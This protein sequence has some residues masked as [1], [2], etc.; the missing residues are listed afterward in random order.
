MT[1]DQRAAGVSSDMVTRFQTAGPNI[2]DLVDTA[3]LSDSSLATLMPA[4]LTELKASGRDLP[5]CNT[6][7]N[8]RDT[9]ALMR[10]LGYAEY[11][12]CDV[13][14]GIKLALKVMRAATKPT[15]CRCRKGCRRWWTPAPRPFPNW[16]RPSTA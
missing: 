13:S 3:K 12:I 2:V 10:T 1:F 7:Q 8:A 6:V 14:D 9:S 15:S 16:T 11:N 5:S 4:C